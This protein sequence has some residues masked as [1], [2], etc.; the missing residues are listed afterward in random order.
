MDIQH[1]HLKI[2]TICRKLKDNPSA[3]LLLKMSMTKILCV[4]H[5]HAYKNKNKNKTEEEEETVHFDG[6]NSI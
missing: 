2:S 6:K 1:F 4:I 5:S 3:L